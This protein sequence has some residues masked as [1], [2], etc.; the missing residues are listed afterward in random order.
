MNQ[1]FWIEI[2]RC[3]RK[4]ISNK[5]KQLIRENIAGIVSDLGNAIITHPHPKNPLD[6]PEDDDDE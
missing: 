4:T 3:W 2:Q 1:A 6:E 5:D